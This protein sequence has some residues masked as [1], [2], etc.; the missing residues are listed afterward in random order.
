MTITIVIICTMWRWVVLVIDFFM[1]HRVDISGALSVCFLSLKTNTAFYYYIL[2]LLHN[3]IQPHTSSNKNEYFWEFSNDGLWYVKLR[4]PGE[5]LMKR[6]SNILSARVRFYTAQNIF[7]MGL[8]VE[9]FPFILTTYDW[10]PFGMCAFYND[11]AV[12]F[13]GFF[14]TNS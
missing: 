10:S 12:V 8:L 3:I 7:S 13:N 2:I 6:M 1:L 9:C 4:E 14:K 5:E 11:T